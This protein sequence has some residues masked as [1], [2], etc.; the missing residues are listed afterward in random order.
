MSTVNTRVGGVHKMKHISALLCV[1]NEE[2]RLSEC[3]ERLG[4]ADEI[5]VVLDR[6]T[7]R[8]EQIAR[9][10]QAVIVK[11][12]FPLEGHRKAAG[13]AAC[14]GAW[15]FEIDADEYVSDNLAAEIL[16]TSHNAHEASHFLVPVDNYVGT[17]LIRHGWGGSFGTNSVVRLYK[18]GAKHWKL[19]RVHPGVTFD[20]KR[21]GRLQHA[22]VHLVDDDVFDMARRLMRYTELRALDIVESGKVGG[23]WSAFFRATRRF[24]KCYIKHQ[25]Y[26]EGTWGV[27]IATM[28]ALFAFLSVL[29]AR[30]MLLE[31]SAGGATMTHER[32]T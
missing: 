23:L 30:L 31:R 28:A 27:L 15:I 26:R 20:G 13:V 19:Q 12:S 3:L 32:R 1:Q 18:R 10:Y 17:K 25:G 11:G 22:L 29:Q 14:S 4:F 2:Q 7:D 16:D 8:S 6:C 24:W 9:K 5:V 21:G